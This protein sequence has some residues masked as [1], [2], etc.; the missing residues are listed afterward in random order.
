MPKFS[1]KSQAL[2]DQVHSDL[3]LVLS[4]AIKHIDFTVLDSTIRTKEQQAQYVKEGKSKTMNSKHLKKFLPKYG[5]EYSLAV[6]IMPYFSSTP[7]T[8]WED[9]LEFCYLAGYILGIA[10]L[11]KSEGLIHSNIVWGGKWHKEK[12]KENTFVDMPHFECEEA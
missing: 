8:D 4:Y 6:D 5:K 9:K 12:V 10:E 3:Q 11:L 1:K 2:L 7:H